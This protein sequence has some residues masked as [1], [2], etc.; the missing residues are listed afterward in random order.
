MRLGIFEL[1]WR[2]L[3]LCCCSYVAYPSGLRDALAGCYL[4]GLPQEF[5]GSAHFAVVSDF[6]CIDC[7][8]LSWLGIFVDV[9]V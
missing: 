5:C 6:F 1:G 4:L 3:V 7:I 9:P 2:L 8:G